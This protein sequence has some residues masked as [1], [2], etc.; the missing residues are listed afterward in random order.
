MRFAL[1]GSGSKG[2]SL[3]IES[4]KTRILI[5][6]GFSGKEIA[7]RMS[8]LQRDTERI[9]GIFL[10]HEHGDHVCGAGVLSR[11]CRLPVYANAGTFRGSEKKIGKVYKQVEFETG[12]PVELQD[13]QVRSF[14]VSHDTADPVGYLINDGTHSIACCTDTGKVSHLVSRRLQGCD[15][16]ILEFNHDPEMLKNGPYPLFLQQRVRSSQGHL[17]NEDAA[18]FLA[19]LLHDRLQHILLAHLS[20]TNN[21]PDLALQSAAAVLD[22]EQACTLLAASQDVPTPLYELK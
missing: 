6:A 19:T 3:F 12:S 5:D 16:L 13:L 21:H 11:R 1:L 17:A 18:A 8:L 14:A 22:R 2:N 7:R 4:G 10:T 20:E 15:A 9:D